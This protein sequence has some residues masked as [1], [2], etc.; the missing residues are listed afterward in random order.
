M[1]SSNEGKTGEMRNTWGGALTREEMHTAEGGGEGN[2]SVRVFEKLLKNYM[3]NDR[4]K[5]S[6]DSVYK[7]TYTV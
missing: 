2:V 6:C 5:K 4:C 3:V 1:R 7:C